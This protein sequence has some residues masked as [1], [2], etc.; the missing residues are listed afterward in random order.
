MIVEVASLKPESADDGEPTALLRWFDHKRGLIYHSAERVRVGALA[1]RRCAPCLAG[2][3]TEPIGK[4]GGEG[5]S[6]RYG[7]AP[8]SWLRQHRA[9]LWRWQ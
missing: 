1:V 5:F 8:Y 4:V 3:Q 9:V 7:V 2:D 6:I